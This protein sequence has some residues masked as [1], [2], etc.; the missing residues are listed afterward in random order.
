MKRFI[1]SAFLLAATITQLKAQTTTDAIGKVLTSYYALKNALVNDNTNLAKASAKELLTDVTNFP[2]DKLDDTQ[3]TTWNTYRE[4][5]EFDS[6]HISES[7]AIAHQ[8]EHFESLS[9]NLYE[10]LAALKLNTAIVYKQYCPMKKS[11]WLSETSTIR[12]PYY[13]KEMPTCGKNTGTIEPAK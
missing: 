2:A 12:N 8:R 5:L 10:V 6:R 13:G 9:K 1:I 3:K 4:K 11:I 7:P